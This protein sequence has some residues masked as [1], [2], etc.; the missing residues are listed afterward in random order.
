M[1]TE[2]A[3]KVK[4]TL[5]RFEAEKQERGVKNRDVGGFQ[6]KFVPGSKSLRDLK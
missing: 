5:S 1:C 3:S 6:D 4:E 2:K